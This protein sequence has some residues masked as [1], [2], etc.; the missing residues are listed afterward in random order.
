M[1]FSSVPVYLD[2]PNWNQHQHQHQ[3]Q[4][5]VNFFAPKPNRFFRLFCFSRFV[6]SL[7]ATIAKTSP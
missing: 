1:V 4:Q 5:Q 2:P 6:S 3:P 7:L